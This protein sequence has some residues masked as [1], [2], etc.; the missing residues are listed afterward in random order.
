MNDL[1]TTAPGRSDDRWALRRDSQAG[2][3]QVSRALSAAMRDLNDEDWAAA[4]ADWQEA[5]VALGKAHD[6]IRRITRRTES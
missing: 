4:Q 5:C 3:R 1:D 2:L 6:A